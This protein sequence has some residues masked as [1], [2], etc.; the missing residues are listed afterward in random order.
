MLRLLIVSIVL[1]TTVITAGGKGR[2]AVI[3]DS[4]THSPLPGASIFNSNGTFIGISRQNGVVDCTTAADYP[5]TIRYI[6]YH[7]RSVTTLS[8][9]TIFLR[10]NISELPEIIVEAKQKK[11]LH[12]LAYEREYSTLSSYTDTVTMFREKMVDFMIPEDKK[13]NF[14]GWRYPRVLNSRSYYQ[15]TNS[16]GLDSVSDRCDNHFTW[17]DWIGTFPTVEIPRRLTDIECGTDT[18]NGRYSPV[19][20]WNRNGDRFSININVLEDTTSRKWV[21]NISSFFDNSKTDFERFR[22]H[23]NYNNVIGN[24]LQPVDLTGYSFNIESRGRG[25]GM[26]RFNR[27]DQPFFVTTYTEVYILDQEYIPVKEA[28]KW[29]K[30]K[31]ASDEIEIFE[32]MEAPDL[33]PSIL[34]LINRVNGIDTDRIRLS[35]QPDH[36]LISRNVSKHNFNNIGYRALSILKQ[37]TGISS[38][39]SRKNLNRHWNDFRINQMRR[40]NRKDKD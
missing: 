36:R 35:Y 28:K 27:H 21:P 37:L 1:A 38:Y 10:E 40:N 8:N 26:F 13:T 23:I 17:S 9:D 4:L 11:M 30:R 14:K 18:V 16:A 7:E 15:F 34:A 3:A 19:E 12:I 32:P 33:Q 39:K 31:F 6:G 24:D 22:L 29:A 20:I 25:R 2:Y 5:L